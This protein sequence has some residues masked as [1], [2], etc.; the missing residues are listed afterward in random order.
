[1]VN[2]AILWGANSHA[3]CDGIQPLGHFSTS[4]I[5]GFNMSVALKGNT[6]V[7]SNL[8]NNT[9]NV[10]GIQTLSWIEQY[11]T[12]IKQQICCFVQ[13]RRKNRC[14]VDNA[15]LNRNS[16]YFLHL[17]CSDFQRI[18]TDFFHKAPSYD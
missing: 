6:F 9:A 4:L 18:E 13:F 17:F 8:K 15:N 11:S 2:N 10:K 14:A 3:G 16:H 5:I 12:K 1:M 7:E